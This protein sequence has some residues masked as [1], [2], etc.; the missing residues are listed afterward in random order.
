[1]R[2]KICQA[3]ASQAILR[4]FEGRKRYGNRNRCKKAKKKKKKGGVEI[5]R[6]GEAGWVIWTN[7]IAL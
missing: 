5:E 3:L 7:F 4:G 2:N 6:G 1:M